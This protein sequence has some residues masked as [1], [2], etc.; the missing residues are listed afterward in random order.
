MPSTRI[1]G[2]RRLKHSHEI[3]SAGAQLHWQLTELIGVTPSDAAR[4]C[5]ALEE[6]ADN[7]VHHGNDPDTRAPAQATATVTFNPDTHKLTITVTDKGPG[8]QRSLRRARTRT[9]PDD[10]ASLL[11][12]THKG[13]TRTSKKDR[14]LGLHS[15]LETAE[16]PGN[17]LKL[18][19][20][21]AT[22]SVPPTGP[23]TCV[24]APP[25]TGT[26]AKLTVAL[27]PDTAAPQGDPSC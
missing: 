12:A 10:C 17:T 9:P 16:I 19:S 1:I 23:T 13:V 5:M 2:P 25:H 14:G 27:S 6:L 3:A 15:T 8:I 22:L 7:A 4:Y 18:Q 11:H 24:P 20:G 26:T 21:T